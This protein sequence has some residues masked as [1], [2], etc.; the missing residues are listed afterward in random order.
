MNQLYEDGEFI[1]LQYGIIVLPDLKQIPE[2]I[3]ILVRWSDTESRN[4]EIQWVNKASVIY[5]SECFRRQMVCAILNSRMALFL[6]WRVRNRLWAQMCIVLSS[7]EHWSAKPSLLSHRLR[8]AFHR[9]PRIKWNTFKYFRRF[10]LIPEW[11]SK[12]FYW[13]SWEIVFSML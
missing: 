2:L 7:Y 6:H 10:V 9:I 8:K 3:R 1:G 11:L 5:I 13:I 4:H 12:I